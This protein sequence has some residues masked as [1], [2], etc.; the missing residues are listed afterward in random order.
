[1]SWGGEQEAAKRLLFDATCLCLSI[2]RCIDAASLPGSRGTLRAATESQSSAHPPGCLVR[3]FRDCPGSCGTGYAVPLGTRRSASGGA[4]R[5]ATL[6][7]SDAPLPRGLVLRYSPSA[8]TLHNASC[9][10]NQAR[11][12]GRGRQ[13]RSRCQSGR[14]SLPLGR[15][16]QR[17]SKF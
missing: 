12:D 5:A 10:R 3:P 16:R 1:M 8:G 14:H 9:R 4:L 7:Q 17:M 11:Y 15:C 2:S 6:L 13:R